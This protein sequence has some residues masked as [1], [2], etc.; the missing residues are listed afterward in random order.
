MKTVY[1]MGPFRKDP[2]GNLK[3]F[4]AMALKLWQA[5]FFAFNPVANCYYM[6][7]L[8]DEDEFVRGDCEAIRRLKFD[9]AILLEGWEDSSGSRREIAAANEVGTIVFTSFDELCEWRDTKEKEDECK[10]GSV[11]A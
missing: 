8:I 1:I 10:R 3:K 2:E 5:G 6:Y 11:G 4:Q 9:A 7:G